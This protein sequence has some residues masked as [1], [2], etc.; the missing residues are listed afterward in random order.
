VAT[1]LVEATELGFDGMQRRRTG[2]RFEIQDTQFSRRWMKRVKVRAQED[3]DEDI[4]RP[5]KGKSKPGR[6]S[7][8]SKI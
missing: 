8:E 2:Q 3:E 7:D 1:I 6:V 4:P 5:T